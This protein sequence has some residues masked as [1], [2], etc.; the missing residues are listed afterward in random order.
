MVSFGCLIV[1]YNYLILRQDTLTETCVGI[2]VTEWG[3]IVMKRLLINIL[4]IE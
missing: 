1:N 4:L 3:I 2:N